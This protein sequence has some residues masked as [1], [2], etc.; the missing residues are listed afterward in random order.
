MDG[1]ENARTTPRSRMPIVARTRAGRPVAEGEAGPRD[2]SSRPH[3]SRY[4]NG[5]MR[6]QRVTREEVVSALRSSGTAIRTYDNRRAVIPNTALFTDKVLVNTAFDKRRLSVRVGIGDG[7][8][9]AEAK[10]MVEAAARGAEGVLA[11]PPP[12]ALMAELG[13]SA[14][15]LDALFW[16]HPPDRGE[17]L[18]A[19][20]RVLARAKPALAGAGID[21]H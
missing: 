1:H 11:D 9:I 19:T 2:R 13:D 5:A 4:L 21:T 18:E 17:I 8:D 20:D 10:R 12:R 6:R 14:V 7:G 3:R 16:I 15:L